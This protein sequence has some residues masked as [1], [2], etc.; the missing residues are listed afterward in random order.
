MAK[1]Q[2][3]VSES[4]SLKGWSF[5]SWL[6]GNWPTIKE[7]LKTGAPFVLALIAGANPFVAGLV[8]I[9]GKFVFDLLHYYLK[10]KVE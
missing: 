1:K 3:V 7:L 5:W 4:L 8:A 2:I 9:V 6:K 10:E